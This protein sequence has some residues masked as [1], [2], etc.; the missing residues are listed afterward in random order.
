MKPTRLYPVLLALFL[1]AACDGS[2]SREDVTQPPTAPNV[3]HRNDGDQQAG[4]TGLPLPTPVSVRV[5]TSNGRPVADVP[6]TFFVSAGGGWTSGRQPVVTNA[7]GEASVIWYMGPNP[8]GTHLLTASSPAGG[9]TFR[10][11]MV[12]HEP[13]AYAGPDRFIELH[14]GT[15]PLV[16][17]AGR[18]GSVRPADVP[19]RAGTGERHEG[20]L[21]LVEE[22]VQVFRERGR[23]MPTVLLSRLDRSKLDPDVL[24]PAGAAPDS[25]AELAWREYHSFLGGVRT[26]VHRRYGAG[27]YIDIHGRADAEPRLEFG[28]LL[29]AADLANENVALDGAAFAQRSS[30]HAVA[31][32]SFKPFS[33][34]ILGPQSLG[35]LFVSRGFAAVPSPQQRIPGANYVS[36]GLSTQRYGSQDGIPVSAVHMQV[37]FAGYRDT[38]A[39]RRRF[40]EHFVA[41]LDAYF[42]AHFRAGLNAEQWRP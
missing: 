4:H 41:V 13:Q 17:G 5:T 36:G 30:M 3:L 6:V 1:T 23:G 16:I 18:G 20:T 31:Q 39:N 2:A 8:Q 29:S 11:N 37:P 32:G 9:A 24:L 34:V 19:D 21:E 40:A 22:I 35:A 33:E 25:R 26:H 28:Y 7:N 27:L 42:A 10:A 38:P 15:L 14:V 12:E